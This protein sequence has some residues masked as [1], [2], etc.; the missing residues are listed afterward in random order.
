MPLSLSPLSPWSALTGV[1]YMK[2]NSISPIIDMI[3]M[4][5]ILKR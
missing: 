1:E 4:A 2:L 5:M 3:D